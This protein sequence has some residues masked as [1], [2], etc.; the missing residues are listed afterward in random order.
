MEY[1]TPYQA[2][3]FCTLIFALYALARPA[4]M[5]P[6]ERFVVKSRLLSRFVSNYVKFIK[7]FMQFNVIIKIK[8]VD[9]DTNKCYTMG[10]PSMEGRLCIE[11][12]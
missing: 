9:F 8:Y 6:E 10:T 7:I 3:F 12:L 4:F 1:I 5:H 2:A 11:K